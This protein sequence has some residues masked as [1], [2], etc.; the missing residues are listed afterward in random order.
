MVHALNLAKLVNA[1]TIFIASKRTI[2]ASL[3]VEMPLIAVSIQTWFASMA[4]VKNLV[5]PSN[6]V[7]REDGA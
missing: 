4:P 2:N 7:N 6:V 3:D 1:P 5:M